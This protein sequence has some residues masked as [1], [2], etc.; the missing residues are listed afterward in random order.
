MDSSWNNRPGG[1]L[2]DAPQRSSF[3]KR[4]APLS[5]GSADAYTMSQAAT[6]HIETHRANTVIPNDIDF[7][8]SDGDMQYV[9]IELDPGES[10]VAEP[11]A[12]IWKDQA[13]SFDMTLGDG[14]KQNAGLGSRLANAGANLLA[15]ESLFLAEFRHEGAAGK[16]RLA[17]GGRIPGHIIPVRLEAMGGTLICQRNSFLAAAKGVSIS[18]AMQRKLMTAICSSEGF[19]MQ[20]LS[21]TG[22]AFLH[23]G[24]SIIERQLGVG[25]VIH[26]DGGCVAAHEPQVTMDIDDEGGGIMRRARSTFMGGESLF[27]TSLRGPGKVWLQ[28]LPFSRVVAETASALPNSESGFGNSNKTSA[29]DILEGLNGLRKLF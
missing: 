21:G 24:G 25:E 2:G 27:L 18:I 12:L 20:R 22:W 23:V 4:R 1:Y 10:V 28:T 3:G 8:I 15:G 14:S 6:P 11:G 13:V 7:Q 5:G 19:I 17:L 29:G 26:V 9:E 16:A